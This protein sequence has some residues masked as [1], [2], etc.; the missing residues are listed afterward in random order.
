MIGQ[1][2]YPVIDTVKTGAKIKQLRE[3]AGISVRDLQTVFNFNS[4][5]AVYKW[6]WGKT[7]PTVDEFIVLARLFKR[8]IENILGIGGE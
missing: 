1:Y 4:P 7:L 2:T 6:Q 8:P 5:Q 3:D